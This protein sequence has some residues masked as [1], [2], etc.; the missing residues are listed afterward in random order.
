MR[1]EATQR[2]AGWRAGGA[3]PLALPCPAA[4]KDPP[5]PHGCCATGAPGRAKPP[6]LCSPMSC[7]HWRELLVRPA[8]MLGTK[9]KPEAGSG[10]TPVLAVPVRGVRRRGNL[11]GC[12][13]GPPRDREAAGVRAAGHE[14]GDPPVASTR[15]VVRELSRGREVVLEAFSCGL[16]FFLVYICHSSF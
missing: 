1:W 3:E 9:H 15:P 8:E 6:S 7:T 10:V 5:W 4:G 13:K 2:D 16:L 12:C 11:P 14:Q